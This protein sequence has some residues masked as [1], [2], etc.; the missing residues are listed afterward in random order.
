MSSPSNSSPHI[1]YATDFSKSA[2]SALI[3]ARQ[4]ARLR[5]ASLHTI[6]VID[7]TGGGSPQPSS[8]TASRESAR[9]AL[10]H[11]EHELRHAGIPSSATVIAAGSAAHSIHESALR[12][13]PEMAVMGSH[14]EPSMLAPSVGANL[15]VVLRR[16][17]Y[18]VLIV[19]ADHCKSASFSFEPV[20]F[21][22]DGDP[23]SLAAAM[24]AWPPPDPPRSVLLYTILSP[25]KMTAVESPDLPPTAFASIRAV[26]AIEAPATL[27]RAMAS[28]Q[29]GLLVIGLRPRGHLDTV[30]AGS[31]LRETI[32]RASCPLLIVRV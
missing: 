16:A 2:Q 19:N 20:I 28:T 14:G 8:F 26:S 27:L 4:I 17:L 1:L 24:A 15:K 13:K 12:Y 23:Q 25:E 29:A 31:M 11:I 21:V 30:A 22:T 7:L 18:P 5:G 10:R 32:T 3:C 6:H 9:R